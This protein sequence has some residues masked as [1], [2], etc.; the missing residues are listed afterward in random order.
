LKNEYA[1]FHYAFLFFAILMMFTRCFFHFTLSLF[2][3]QPEFS[4]TTPY[5]IRLRHCY[6]TRGFRF[7]AAFRHFHL[8]ILRTPL[9][10]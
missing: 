8:G 9:K 6:F 1:R 5:V 7:A 10:T 4:D 3:G 2:T